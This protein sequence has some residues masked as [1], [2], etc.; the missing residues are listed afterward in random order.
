VTNTTI[1]FETITAARFAY[2]TLQP[3]IDVSLDCNA[4]T[5]N[6]TDEEAV[7]W[8]VR[9]SYCQSG[10]AFNIYFNK[11]LILLVDD[12][13]T[14]LYLVGDYLE[15][16][17]LQVISASSEQQGWELYC[18]N[19]PALIVS[20]IAMTSID[21]GFRLIQRV[22]ENNPH[23]PFIF[24]SGQMSVPGKREKAVELGADAC[25]GKPFEPSEL[26]SAIAQLL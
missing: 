19:K 26:L 12:D 8:L 6:P 3:M 9:D 20:G 22:R 18:T 15:D 2:D 17:G 25:F 7:R 4:L 21:C 1:L 24:L 23:Q 16:K 13:A 10:K 14:F 11:K 5:Y